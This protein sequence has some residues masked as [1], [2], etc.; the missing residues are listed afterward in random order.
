MC[1]CIDQI[2]AAEV[3]KVLTKHN[4]S[5]AVSANWDSSVYARVT[6][7]QQRT[8]VIERPALSLTLEYTKT[9]TTGQPFKRA[10]VERIQIKPKF[11][12]MCGGKL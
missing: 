9:T 8:R 1:K 4:P 7:K 12:S 6:N 5:G 10:T 11:C 2:K 3:A